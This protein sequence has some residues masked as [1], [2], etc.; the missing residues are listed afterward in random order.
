MSCHMK[1]V[2]FIAV[3]YVK[4][5]DIYYQKQ[6]FI[7]M[8]KELDTQIPCDKIMQNFNIRASICRSQIAL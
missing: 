7:F 8:K 5:I 1:F 3:K 4:F 6:L 2:Y